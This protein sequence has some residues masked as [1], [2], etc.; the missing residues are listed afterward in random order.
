ME[1]NEIDVIVEE[2]ME[3]FHLY[4]KIH[5]D[6]VIAQ[7]AFET[8]AERFEK[9]DY[10]SNDRDQDI[11]KSYYA[12]LHLVLAIGSMIVKNYEVAILGISN[13]DHYK[14][15]LYGKENSSEKRK[16]M[17]L[18]ARTKKRHE[19]NKNL[20]IEHSG[21]ERQSHRRACSCTSDVHHSS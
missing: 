5:N 15:V 19:K 9:I 21:K 16:V 8:I 3:F 13:V 20:E 6:F 10:E 18:L 12:S 4:N 11:L 14:G 7:A 2:A 1:L 17:E